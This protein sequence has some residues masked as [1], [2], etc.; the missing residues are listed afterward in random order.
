MQKIIKSYRI[1]SAQLKKWDYGSNAIYFVTI[2]TKHREN[3]LGE[4]QNNNGNVTLNATVM[5]KLA[6]QNWLKIPEHFPFI[7]LD[8]FSI[9]PDHMHGLLTINKKDK[10]D[11]KPNEFGVQSKNLGSVIRGFKASLKT[12]ATINQ[13]PFAWQER[14]HDSVIRSAEHLENVREYIINNQHKHFHQEIFL[15]LSLQP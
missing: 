8:V 15:Q 4:L 14:Y 7:E 2:N 1:D 11:W 6:E 12:F 9:L 3:F 10:T 13:I 5:G